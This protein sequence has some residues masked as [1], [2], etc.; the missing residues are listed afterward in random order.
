MYYTQSLFFKNQLPTYLNTYIFSLIKF[1][2]I[3]E[4]L[5]PWN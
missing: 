1:Y 4:D 5:G 2:I 3:F